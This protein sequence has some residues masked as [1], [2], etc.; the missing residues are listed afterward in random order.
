[1]GGVARGKV[2]RVTFY[3]TLEDL[4]RHGKHVWA[5]IVEALALEAILRAIS[6][7]LDVLADHIGPLP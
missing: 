2:A 1:M 7:I 6:R 4:R 5:L 3:E